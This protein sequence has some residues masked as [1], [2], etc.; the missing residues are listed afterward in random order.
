MGDLTPSLG[1]S[2][3]EVFSF[4]DT[5]EGHGEH[6]AHPRLNIAVSTLS[7]KGLCGGRQ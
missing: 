1:A 4:A 6:S 7:K 3:P 5:P 2:L